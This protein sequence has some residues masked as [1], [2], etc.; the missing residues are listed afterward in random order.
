MSS[1]TRMPGAMGDTP[2][3][4]EPSRNARQKTKPGY[5]YVPAP[6]PEPTTTS[7][8]AGKYVGDKPGET[9]TRSQTKALKKAGGSGGAAS[10]PVLVSRSNSKEG[11]KP[12]PPTVKANR[13][14]STSG[15]KKDGTLRRPI[16]SH[17]PDD[18]QKVKDQ[19]EKDGDLD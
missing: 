7:G 12:L 13:V 10:P 11:V 18:W 4:G 15:N 6:A 8:L 19:S 14:V 16:T 9:K 1:S 17:D 5:D 2:T 3:K